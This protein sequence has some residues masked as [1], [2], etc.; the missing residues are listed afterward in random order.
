MNKQTKE[1]NLFEWILEN[2]NEMKREWKKMKENEKNQ[3]NQ[4]K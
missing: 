2:I 3:E 4:E 1:R